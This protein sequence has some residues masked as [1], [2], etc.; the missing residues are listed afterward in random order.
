MNTLPEK[1]PALSGSER[2]GHRLTVSCG[3]P[4]HTCPMPKLFTLP[5]RIE[6]TMRKAAKVDR[7]QPEIVEA[8]RRAGCSVQSLASIGKGCPDLIVGRDGQNF[9][10]EVKD[11]AKVPSA[12]KL[13][14]DEKRWHENWSG[15]VSIIEDIDQALQLVSE[16]EAKE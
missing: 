9:L 1:Q 2:G 14:E 16:G 15:Q 3:Q 5:L 13:T 7:N 12:R 6:T 8:L 4:V 10:I 11:G